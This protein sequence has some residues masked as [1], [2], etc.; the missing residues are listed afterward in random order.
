MLKNNF[1]QKLYYDITSYVLSYEITHEKF[2]SYAEIAKVFQITWED[3]KMYSIIVQNKNLLDLSTDDD[4]RCALIS[5]S[6]ALQKC[7]DTSR[8]LRKDVREYDRLPNAIEELH[9]EMIKHLDTHKFHD[10]IPTSSSVLMS[11]LSSP[12]DNAGVIHITDWHLNEL[13]KMTGINEFNFNRASQMIKKLVAY[14]IFKWKAM[15]VRKI[16]V[17]STGDLLNTFLAI[18]LLRAM[19]IDL[20]NH[21]E[22]VYFAGVTGNESRVADELGWSEPLITD[23]YDYTIYKTIEYLFAG[24]RDIHVINQDEIGYSEVPINIS[25][26]WWLLVHGHA[27]PLQ[28]DVEKGI[29]Q[30]MGKWSDA[31]YKIAFV[32]LG[33][34]HYTSYNF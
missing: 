2:P 19:L 21:F 32:L 29:I 30:L 8:L 25:G 34:I 18:E 14:S 3:A 7:R 26:H 11:I 12:M 5:K 20:S 13:I 1:K 23:N 4:L 15:G 10:P 27:R 22:K 33:H 17:L 28:G 24:H 16:A 9:K 6:K 31:G